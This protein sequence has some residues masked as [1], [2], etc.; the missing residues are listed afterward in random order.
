MSDGAH[1]DDAVFEAAAPALEAFLSERRR[2]SEV[3]DWGR[4][5]KDI[6]A[7]FAEDTLYWLELRSR[8]VRLRDE[9]VSWFIARRAL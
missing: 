8:V 9:G 5:R 4:D 1:R 6:G 2:L 7:L 3:K